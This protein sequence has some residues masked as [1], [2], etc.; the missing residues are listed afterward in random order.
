MFYVLKVYWLFIPVVIMYAKNW[1]LKRRLDTNL[2]QV[3]I[4]IK[5]TREWQLGLKKNLQ[6]S[7]VKPI[8]LK[9]QKMT[10]SIMDLFNQCE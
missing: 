9:T 10:I 1:F 5:H 3:L 2:Y 6:D 8:I 4:D 7:T